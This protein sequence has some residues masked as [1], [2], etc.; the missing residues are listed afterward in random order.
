MRF[1]SRLL[2]LGA[3][4]NFVFAQLTADQ[5]LQ[6]FQALAAL[7]AKRYAPYEWKRD[8]LHYDLLNIAPWLAK[9]QASKDDLS[10]YEILSDY[11]ANLNDAHSNY[12]LPSTFV[13]RL[14]FTVD[15]FEG[16]LLVESINRARLPATEFGFQ[17][18][19]QL[20]SIDGRDAPG[21]LEGLLRY[22]TAAN[23]RTTRRFAATLLTT[24]SQ[25][26]MPHAAEVPDNS[27]VVFR[28]PDGKLESYGIPWTA[29]GLP[30]VNVG[31]YSSLS[32]A[33]RRIPR[34]TPDEP[35]DNAELPEYLQLLGRLQNCRIP[36]KGVTG[37]GIPSPVF[38]PS[39]PDN[40]VLRLGRS[41]PDPFFS[42]VFEAAGHKIGF[43]RIP[44][45]APASTSAALNAFQNEISFF[46]ANTDGLV[47]DNMRNP[48][49]SVSYVNQILR[50]LM[51][52]RWSSILFEVRATSEWVLSFSGAM[53][54]LRT[55]GAPQGFID[56]YQAIRDSII[57]ANRQVRGRT[58]PIPL[59]DVAAD[60]D[61][62]TDWQGKPLAYSKPMLVLVDEMTASAAEVL[63]ATIQD[64]GRAPLFGW[65]TM[66]AGGSVESWPAGAYSLGSASVTQ[67][68]MI[69]KNPVV[70]AEYP[71]AP[72]VENIGVHPEIE[73]DYMTRDNLM[74]GGKP[75]VE[76]LIAAIVAEVEKRR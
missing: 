10:F 12:T 37:Y 53:E 71:T 20:V 34:R 52:F 18:G 38:A 25:S 74:Q 49:G 21:L 30:L 46:Q 56:L 59:D 4:P 28:R 50:Y 66:G 58:R 14:N 23:P 73:A 40:F 27:I 62:I 13:A 68:M 41:A 9:V 35:E 33:W 19:Y 55:L 31:K 51:P 69:R 72:Y 8:A 11:V 42:G 39:L 67:S 76:A 16:Q 57:D 2:L 6:D 47:V 44:S 43:I 7:Y 64:N 1:F 36:D 65:R 24:R 32:A 3:I 61:P 48:G 45:Y 5:K 26:R 15:I 29:S 22:Q 75:F 54:Q 60:R 70:S 63:A 17:I